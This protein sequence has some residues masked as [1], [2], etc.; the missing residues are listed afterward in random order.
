M[1]VFVCRYPGCGNLFHEGQQIPDRCPNGDH[2][3]FAEKDEEGQP[4]TYTAQELEGRKKI[5]AEA[6]K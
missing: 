5:L 1:S 4:L 3:P 6:Q 2:S